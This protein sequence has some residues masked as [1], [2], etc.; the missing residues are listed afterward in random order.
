MIIVEIALGIVLAF[1]ILAF[2]PDIIGIGL[3]LLG[4]GLVIAVVLAAIYAT[5]TVKTVAIFV[6]VIA[7]I[8]WFEMQSESISPQLKK[9]VVDKDVADEDLSTR[10]KRYKVRKT[11]NYNTK[12]ISGN[13]IWFQWVLWVS[14]VAGVLFSAVWF[15]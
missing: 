13:E 12:K 1:I 5:G 14:V 7:G 10:L 6:I 4:I 3:L 11:G 9:D 8:I 15:R 2:L